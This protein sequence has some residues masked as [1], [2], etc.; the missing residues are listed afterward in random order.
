MIIV[1]GLSGAGKT[2]ALHTL[3][4]LGYY[5]IDNL[6]G[7]LLPSLYHEQLKINMPVA[8][9]IDIRSQIGDIDKLI[10][11]IDELK[12]LEKEP[13][14][15]FLTANHAVLVKRFSESRRKHPLTSHE[16]TLPESIAKEQ[17]ILSPLLDIADYTIDTSYLSV[18]DLKDRIASW[19]DMGRQSATNTTIESFGF[20]HGIPI[21][22]DLIF[23]VRF[24][25]NPH[26]ESDLRPLTGQDKAVRDFLEQS[27]SVNDYIKDTV[28]YL[29]KWLPAFIN[30]HRSYLTIAIGCTGGKHRSVY[31]AEKIAE[32]LQQTFGH[33]NV[34]HRD[35]P[36]RQG[37]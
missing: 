32:C 3:E 4:D 17:T 35:M 31:S 25:P 14:I 34:R 6:P 5:C 37:E 9:G 21:D 28:D 7:S 1:S 11:T 19:L 13:Q 2:V 27:D 18:Y 26:W 33:I 10:K 22:A 12:C 23:D 8:V 15:L 29:T 20:K 16:S 36:T 24:L 30:G